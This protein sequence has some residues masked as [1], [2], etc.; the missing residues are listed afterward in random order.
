MRAVVIILATA[1]LIVGASAPA[2]AHE[3]EEEVPAHTSVEEAI[4]ILATQP[5]QMD[6]IEDKIGD[7]QESDDTDGV[8]VDVVAKAGD[9]LDE[10]DLD[11]TLLL[12]ERSIGVQPGQMMTDPTSGL[13]SAAPLPPSE[14][15]A[16]SPLLAE[17]GN[18]VSISAATWLLILAVVSIA[19]GL[20]V[21]RRY[22]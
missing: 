22:R 15:G 19:V 13:P 11:T 12:L 18:T 16:G 10:G 9:A 1:G 4:A 6:A 21:V 17:A 2:W 20:H 7:A 14:L 5:E 8:D 3:G